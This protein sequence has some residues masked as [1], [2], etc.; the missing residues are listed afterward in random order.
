[1]RL[2]RFAVSVAFAAFALPATSQQSPADSSIGRAVVAADT[3]T[4][5]Q[6]AI[7]GAITARKHPVFNRGL[8]GFA[9]GLPIGF[10]L[11]LLIAGIGHGAPGIGLG[12]GILVGACCL[13]EVSLPPPVSAS[14]RSRGDSFQRAFEA[15]Y[16]HEVVERRKNA[17][18]KG[19]VAG[20]LAG[21]G[22]LYFL[23]SQI[24]T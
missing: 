6:G 8:A 19:A 12:G 20:S 10:S 13:G 1:M 18:T 3:G 4:A 14:I 23:L 11:P 15:S 22:V 17:A 16:R 2:S 7:A 21:L 5:G 9:A 24:T